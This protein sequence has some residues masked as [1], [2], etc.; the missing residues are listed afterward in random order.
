MNYKI[1]LFY[2]T[3]LVI[4]PIHIF[5]QNLVVN[6]SFEITNTNCS[7]MG[8]ES[9]RQD[10]DPSWDNANSNIPGDSCSSSDL[11]S[12]CNVIPIL[13][14]PAPTH[15]PNSVLG[16]QMS[17]TGTRHAGIILYDAPFGISSNY[18]EYLQGHTTSPLVAG[19]TYCVSFY[20]SLANEVAYATENIGVYFTNTHYLRD[21]CAQGSRINVTPQL[22]NTCGIITDTM[23][24][25]R[26]QWD[27]TATGGEQYF[28]IGNFDNDANTN[29]ITFGSGQSAFMNP[30][31][32][33]YID[34]VSIIENSCC[35]AEINPAPSP[36]VNDAPFNL[37]AGSNTQCA[38]TIIGTWS[39]PGITNATLGTFDPSVAGEGTHSISFTLDCGYIAKIDITVKA[40]NLNVCEDNGQLT[41]SG[42]TGPYTWSE[43]VSG[44]TIPITDQASCVQCGGTWTFGTCLGGGLPP[45]PITSCSTPPGYDVF[46]T[47]TTVTPPSNLPIIVVD[48]LGDTLTINSLAGIPQCTGCN[49]NNATVANITES[50]CN[51]PI[52]LSNAVSNA[53]G[54]TITYYGTQADA[55]NATNA[56]SSSVST[57]GTYWVRIEDPNDPTCFSVQQIQVT[58]STL[59][60]TS[61]FTDENCNAGDGS[62]TLTASGGVSPYQ[63]SIDGGNTLQSNG[64]FQNLGAGTYSV[65]IVDS[66]GCESTETITIS[67]IGGP[68]IDNVITT[69]PSCNGMC[70]GEIEITVSGGNP[71]YTYI[72]KDGNGNVVGG[73]TSTLSNICDGNYSVEV[74]NAGGGSGGTGTTTSLFYEDFNSGATNWNLNVS[75]APE[76]S[77]AN[78]FTVSDAE[79]GV[80]PGGCGVAN[81]GDAT[82]HITS[83][84]MPNGGAA[85]DAGGLCGILFCPE[86]HRRAESPLINTV[87]YTGLSLNFDYIANGAIPNDQA[88]VWYNDGNGWTQ[89]G[90]ALNSGTCPNTQ[91]LWSAYSQALPVSCENINNL[92]I[93]IRWD[94]NDDG[95]GT[96]PSVAINNLEIISSTGGGGAP[97]SASQTFTLTTNTP[98]ASFTGLNNDY[99]KSDTSIILV[100]TQANGTFS[101][102]GVNGNTFNPQI[103]GNGTHT[104]TYIVSY[105]ANCADTV[106][107][108]VIISG[109]NVSFTADPTQTD[110][111]N[112]VINFTNTSTDAVNYI[113]DFGDTTSNEFTTN[114]THT[115]SDSESG[116]YT[117]TLVGYDANGCM[118]I[119]QLVITILEPESRFDVPN[120]FTPNGDND[121]DFFKLIYAEN[122]KSLNIFIVNR[123]NNTVF[124]SDE[125]QFAWNGKVNNVGA[126]CSEGVYF[127]VIKVTSFSGNEIE[128]NG[129]IHL[130]RGK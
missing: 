44:S 83:V 115:Y 40:C 21:A 128:R 20:I 126:D 80:S 54:F 67:N 51:S 77:D 38:N 34:D 118:D 99:C 23:G 130:V 29:Q 17:R 94:N 78:F 93:A 35:Y 119:A 87:G 19:Q 116:T 58:I 18:R 76:G 11:F 70:D 68:V 112:T 92:Q 14:T 106:T 108:T 41:V 15:M 50:S 2:I 117:V 60:H 27:Y 109:P 95:V 3:L 120:V 71:P 121:N 105:G 5:S 107:K 127:Y 52:N 90:N 113:W 125:V 110:L 100:P 69:N 30:Y 96:D 86:T 28:I 49:T 10:L 89:L 47:G 61:S 16:W 42:G 32:Y 88:T 24:W 53:S 26:L 85:Y 22:T 37:S 8:G 79:G 73:N 104:I 62:I 56:I 4:I 129:Y 114:A 33:Y 84:F 91:G 97:C 64:G 12:A 101:G 74:I 6:P 66:K 7:Q 111:D 57:P 103:A 1:K 75:L 36:C 122:I 45:M 123:W 13:N 55:N 81:N 43:W 46:A 9:F 59:T 65:Y 63:Y 82:L 31:A 98:D 72:W 102:P 124:E 39:G 48:A 25:K